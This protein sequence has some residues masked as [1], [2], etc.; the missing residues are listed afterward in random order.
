MLTTLETV[1]PL[2]AGA[3]EAD[4]AEVE[5]LIRSAS[6]RI[7]TYCNRR[8]GLADHDDVHEV[9]FPQQYLPLRQFPVVSLTEIFRD[10]A[11]QGLAA[12]KL[13]VEAGLLSPRHGGRWQPGEYRI[14]YRAGFVLPDQP[15]STLPP[16]LEDAAIEL[17]RS[18][19]LARER[20]PHLKSIEIPDIERREYWVGAQGARSLPSEIAQRVDPFRM[21]VIG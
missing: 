21:P 3:A 5:R 1:L 12:V 20:D 14:T 15:N 4:R 17:V 10:G 9:D 2:L 16:D 13:Q 19:W 11:P 18:M 8:F 7:E 6:A